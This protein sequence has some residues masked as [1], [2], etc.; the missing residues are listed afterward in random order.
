M[1]QSAAYAACVWRTSGHKLACFDLKTG[2]KAWEKPIAGDIITAPVIQDN[3]LYL[4]TL[5]GTMY[6]FKHTDGQLV[7]QEKK[8]ATSSPMVWNGQCYFSRRDETTVKNKDGKEVKQQMESLA[9]RPIT[10]NGETKEVP[11][12]SRPADYLDY[13]KRFAYSANE[14]MFKKAEGGVGF[15]TPPAD[16]NLPQA[17]ANLGQGTVAGVWSFQGS[18]PFIANGKLFTA[19]GDTMKCVDPKTEKILWKKE[20]HQKDEKKPLLD[21]AVT[22]PAIVNGKIFVGTTRGE[23]M[24][25]SAEKGDIL[26]TATIGEPIVFQPAVANGRVY[27]STST[28][29]LYAIE[30]GDAKD[31]GWLMWGGNAQHNGLVK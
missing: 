19:M 12:T 7:W 16:A 27:V 31:D 11:G 3:Q 13:Q 2:K 14:Q 20:L 30:T 25:L 22:P 26:W 24:C 23:V 29:S 8:N 5:E 28:G 10:K 6:C 21:S 17:M 4:A 15:A 18:R 9:L 1:V